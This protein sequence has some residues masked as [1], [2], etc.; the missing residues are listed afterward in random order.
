[1]KLTVNTA[2]GR[3][4]AMRKRQ[5][6]HRLEAAT[7]RMR[8]PQLESMQLDFVFSDRTDFIPSP[9]MTVFHPPAP[10]YFCFACPY[11]NCDGAFDLTRQVELAVGAREIA[12]RGQLRC[13]GGRHGGTPCTLCV[14]YSIAPRWS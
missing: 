7:I 5:R 3:R 10:A 14:E 13:T 9:L 1:M 4:D 2:G 11:D 8:Y 12:S 6:Q